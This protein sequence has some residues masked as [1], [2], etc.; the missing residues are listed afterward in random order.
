M[1]DFHPRHLEIMDMRQEEALGAFS[2]EDAQERIEA[3]SEA[4]I[5]AGTFMY[6]GRILCCA[7]FSML[8]PGVAN[9]WII[10]FTNGKPDTISFCKLIK[11]YVD[12]IMKSF[13]CHRFQTTS[14][15]DPFHER[16]MT[17]LG[18]KK[19][20]TMEKYTHDKKNQ[21]IYARVI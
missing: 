16:W 15:D 11:G 4:S 17:W 18:F 12:S 21:C 7:G 13:N 5:K 20:G 10:L 3:I 8:W 19:E 14:F 9:G 1:V 2:M 6:D